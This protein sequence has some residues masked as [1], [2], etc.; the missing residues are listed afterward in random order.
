MIFP[1]FFLIYFATFIIKKIKN[2]N[3]IISAKKIL[4]SSIDENLKLE[5]IYKSVE[6]DLFS[7]YEKESYYY[8]NI[9]AS[10]I[11][12]INLNEDDLKKTFIIF[13]L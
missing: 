1:L 6:N 2:N 12:N 4:F 3:D 13:I 9:K 8:I 5:N 7:L 10:S 11:K